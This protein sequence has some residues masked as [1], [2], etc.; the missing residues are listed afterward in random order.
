MNY[1][2]NIEAKLGFDKIREQTLQKCNT[3]YARDWLAQTTFCAKFEEVQRHLLQTAEM[4]NICHFENNFPPIEFVDVQH[5]VAKIKVVGGY[6][7]EEELLL[8]Q[9]M[10]EAVQQILLFL[11]HSHNNKD[12]SAT[13]FPEI[14]KLAASVEK[15]PQVKD[16]IVRIIDPMGKVRDNASP[17][18]LQLRQEIQQV[19]RQVLRRTQQA[20][21]SAQ[22]EGYT[23]EGAQVGFRDG[24]TVIP[25]AA[26]SKRKIAGIV[27]DESATGKT[28]FV[29]PAEVVELNNH[30]KELGFAE[31]REV[32]KILQE[33]ANFARPF[34]PQIEQSA[35]FLGQIDFLRAKAAIAF[36][37]KAVL[38]VLVGEPF[39][40]WHQARHP[41]LEAA[42][43]KDG[44]AIVPL[45][46]RLTQQQSLLLISGPNAGGKSV[47]LKTVGL[48]QYMAQCGFLVPMS[49]R[50][51]MGV[52]DSVFIDIGDEQSLENDLSTYSSHLQNMRYF[53]RYAHKKTLILIDEFGTGTEP[54]LGGAIAQ[55]I[56]QQLVQQKCFGVITTHY[57]NLKQYASATAGIQNGAMLFDVE[58]IEPLFQLKT[59]AAGSSFAFEIAQKTG[60]PTAVLSSAKSLLGE[61]HLNFDKGLREISRDKKYWEAKREHIKNES[62]NLEE[63]LAKYNSALVLLQTERKKIL[64]EAKQQAQQL[65][66]DA[67]REIENTIR[68][69]KEAQAQKEA[70]QQLRQRLQQ[71]AQQPAQ[72][73]AGDIL[74]QKITQVEQLQQRHKPPV[75]D[76]NQAL[77]TNEITTSPTFNVGDWVQMADKNWIGE[78]VNINDSNTCTIAV[79]NMLT[80]ASIE[81]LTPLSNNEA[82]KAQAAQRTTRTTTDFSVQR[83]NFHPQID[84]RGQRVEETLPQVETWLDQALMFGFGALKILHGKGTGALKQKIRQY[85][86]SHAG[87]KKFYD[88]HVELGGAGIT[89]IEMV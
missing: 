8:L 54:Q 24:R 12:G 25:V 59:G 84:V 81:K 64:H 30:L 6:L 49:E 62:K 66:S 73:K 41:L 11:E 34:L 33:F 76:R 10:L 86:S 7:L 56:L 71:Y 65:L 61:P 28:A 39:I 69:I 58:K 74:L 80:T 63:Q 87:V 55:A 46:F 37:M 40:D 43:T 89:V 4:Y 44:K 52:F 29:E 20:L 77:A 36:Q 19:Q 1:P 78:I 60:L 47:C 21:K 18:L 85:L 38:P 83:L 3:Q 51:E 50:S 14:V 32:V 15:L 72:D 31:R 88:E 13:R 9:K 35:Q 67:N 22:A 42:L 2:A 70:T 75:P 82:K 45:S 53:L 5:F 17:A 48:L 23:D 68:G 16:A 57:A 27:L 79:G 26:G